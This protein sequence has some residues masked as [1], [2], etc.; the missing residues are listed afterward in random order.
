MRHNVSVCDK[1]PSEKSGM[2]VCRAVFSDGLYC[3]AKAAVFLSARLSA[4]QGNQ[5]FSDGL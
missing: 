5:V 4:R 2:V 3:I 1:R